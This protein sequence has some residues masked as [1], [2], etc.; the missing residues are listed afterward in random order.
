VPCADLGNAMTSRIEE[1]L[2]RMAMSLSK[3]SA[4]PPWGGAPHERACRSCA[5]GAF[6]CGVSC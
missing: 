5:K 4:I 6:S 3:P 2:Q 1:A